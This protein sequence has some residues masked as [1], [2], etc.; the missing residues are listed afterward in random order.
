M[1]PESRGTYLPALLRSSPSH[2]LAVTSL[3]FLPAVSLPGG[4]LRMWLG[5]SEH[6]TV[7]SREGALG[8]EGMGK[9]ASQ[10]ALSSTQLLLPATALEEEGT[11]CVSGP[12]PL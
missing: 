5:C 1:L 11:R 8:R 4:I 7:V 6:S 3:H 9:L 12:C 2:F 10:H